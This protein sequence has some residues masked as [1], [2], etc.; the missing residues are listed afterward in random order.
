MSVRRNQQEQNTLHA[1]ATEVARHALA[2]CRLRG[3]PAAEEYRV[4]ADRL[5]R[6]GFRDLPPGALLAWI[7]DTVASEYERFLKL[8]ALGDRFHGAIARGDLAQ[9]AWTLATE[10]DSCARQ[11]LIDGISRL[12]DIERE[13]SE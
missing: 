5:Y 1:E 4:V 6:S 13:E 3:L 12:N 7:E 2:E 9:A 10:L 8:R 11:R